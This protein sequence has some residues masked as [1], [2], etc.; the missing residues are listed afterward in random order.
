MS[1]NTSD[2]KQPEQRVLCRQVR[3]RHPQGPRPARGSHELRVPLR[4]RWHPG[5]VLRWDGSQCSPGARTHRPQRR[6]L[7]P[8]LRPEEPATARTRVHRE[9]ITKPGV[10]ACAFRGGTR[11]ACT[12]LSHPGTHAFSDSQSHQ[13]RLRPCTSFLQDPRG[14]VTSHHNVQ[15]HAPRQGPETSPSHPSGRLLG[16]SRSKPETKVAKRSNFPLRSAGHTPV[17]G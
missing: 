16:E 14:H 4:G 9:N 3:P 6:T 17:G 11:E 15:G 13:R 2:E 5:P 10:G 8:S 12:P 7:R 1:L